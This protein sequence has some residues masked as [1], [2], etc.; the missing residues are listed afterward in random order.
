VCKFGLVLTFK[1]QSK[2]LCYVGVFKVQSDHFYNSKWELHLGGS[3][4]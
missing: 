3:S 4:L 1:V 2:R